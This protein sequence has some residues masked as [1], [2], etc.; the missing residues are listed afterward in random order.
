MYFN[1]FLINFNLA[2]TDV[3]RNS[4]YLTYI[5]AAVEGVLYGKVLTITAMEGSD[6]VALCYR[7]LQ[8]LATDGKTMATQ[9][10]TDPN[11]FITQHPCRLQ[12]DTGPLRTLRGL[13]LVIVW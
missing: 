3:D 6:N 4:H 12:R 10:I 13:T 5:I 7:V 1:F 9:V 8:C 11:A 2:L